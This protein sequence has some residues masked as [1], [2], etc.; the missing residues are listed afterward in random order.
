MVR[1]VLLSAL[2]WAFSTSSSR[3]FIGM[4]E[5]TKLAFAANVISGIFSLQF[6]NFI[7]GFLLDVFVYGAEMLILCFTHCTTMSIHE[8]R[9]VI[10]L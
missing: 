3:R 2:V 4:L 7:I 9:W 10:H 5:S 8:L 1:Q 6:C